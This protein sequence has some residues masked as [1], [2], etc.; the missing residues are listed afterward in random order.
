MDAL[1]NTHPS[2]IGYVDPFEAGADALA[3]SIAAAVSAGIDDALKD[4]MV[5]DV[6]R[7]DRDDRCGLKALLA[8]M[9]AKLGLRCAQPCA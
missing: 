5:E 4:P 2:F 3:E 9:A 7:T 1:S 8:E 6:I